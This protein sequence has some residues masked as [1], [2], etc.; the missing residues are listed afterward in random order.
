MY[1]T[2][3]RQD[4]RKRRRRK[5]KKKGACSPTFVVIITV[6]ALHGGDTRSFKSLDNKCE[7]LSSLTRSLAGWINGSVRSFDRRARP[8]V[9]NRIRSM[10]VVIASLLSLG[11]AIFPPMKSGPI[12]HIHARC[13]LILSSLLF[14]TNVRYRSRLIDALRKCRENNIFF[15]FFERKLICTSRFSLDMQENLFDQKWISSDVTDLESIYDP[16][17]RAGLLVKLTWTLITRSFHTG[18]SI[19][20]NGRLP[21]TR[22]AP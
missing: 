15:F 4:R 13:N 8:G 17:L 12:S 10:P 22:V 18:Y 19:G 7:I 3:L 6:T 9:R 11:A 14:L 20:G 2:Y 1:M 21:I 16:T 5:K